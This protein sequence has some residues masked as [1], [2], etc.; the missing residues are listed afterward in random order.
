MT[1]KCAAELVAVLNEYEGDHV[2]CFK[3][4]SIDEMKALRAADDQVGLSTER[5]A[6]EKWDKGLVSIA[7]SQADALVPQRSSFDAIFN[8]TPH[9]FANS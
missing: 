2:T 1:I 5:P 8:T 6:C 7:A 4:L 9:L 3:E